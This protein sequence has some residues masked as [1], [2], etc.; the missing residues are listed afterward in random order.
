[1]FLEINR[2]KYLE[3]YK[4]RMWFNNG[5]VRDVDLAHSLKG[6]VFEPLRDKKQFQHFSIRFNTIEWENGA[7][8]APEYLYENSVPAYDSCKAAQHVVAE[9]QDP[10][11]LSK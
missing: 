2:A 6:E 8:L 5:E 10:Y 7:D 3:E 4:I 9:E 11:N 1:M